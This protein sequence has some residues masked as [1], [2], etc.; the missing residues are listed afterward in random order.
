MIKQ[1]MSGHSEGVIT[2]KT[3]DVDLNCEISNV[4]KKTG[5]R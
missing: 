5:K 4:K 2:D 1:Y 3:H